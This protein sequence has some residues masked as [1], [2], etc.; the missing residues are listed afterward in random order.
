MAISLAAAEEIRTHAPTN[1]RDDGGDYIAAKGRRLGVTIF[2]LEVA[3]GFNF[4]KRSGCRQGIVDANG[5]RI[6]VGCSRA[7]NARLAERNFISEIRM[8]SRGSENFLLS[9]HAT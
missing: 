3:I 5:V 2:I 1:L 9:R 6:S 4:K 8:K 7:S